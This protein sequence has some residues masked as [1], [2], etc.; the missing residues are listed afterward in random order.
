M[1]EEVRLFRFER[2]RWLAMNG[3]LL[4]FLKAHKI[5]VREVD[6]IPVEALEGEVIAIVERRPLKVFDEQ[7]GIAVEARRDTRPTIGDL[8]KLASRFNSQR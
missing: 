1:V 8:Q 4:G 7:L 6:H 2:G 3:E 5:D